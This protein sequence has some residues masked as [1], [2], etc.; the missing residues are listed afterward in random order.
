MI[1]SRRLASSSPLFTATSTDKAQAKYS[2][3][4]KTMEY[5]ASGTPT[6]MYNL[7]GLP[8]EYHNYCFIQ[9][10]LSIDSLY[11]RI[12]EICEMDSDY[13][14][15]FGQKARR[16]ILENKTPEAQCLLVYNMI[17]G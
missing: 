5:L 9:R 8:M 6:L 4:S 13:L 15:N 7:E 1:A 12:L 17:R 2:F 10:D 3:P 14:Y 11:K 16:F